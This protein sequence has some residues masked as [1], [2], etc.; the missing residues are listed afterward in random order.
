MRRSRGKRDKRK[1]D[2][3]LWRERVN[4]AIYNDKYIVTVPLVA[5][6]T[7]QDRDSLGVPSD[8]NGNEYSPISVGLSIYEMALVANNGLYV[9]IGDQNQIPGIYDAINAFL[10]I[11]ETHGFSLHG[12]KPKGDIDVLT[13][14]QSMVVENN[15]YLLNKEFSSRGERITTKARKRKISPKNPNVMVV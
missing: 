6:L 14:F 2:E 3:E 13:E 15:R 12:R 5:T 4:E 11:H 8:F 10:D 9:R 1:S 7:N